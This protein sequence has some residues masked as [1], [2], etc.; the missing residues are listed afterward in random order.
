MTTAI[1]CLE[2]HAAALFVHDVEGRLVCT[3]DIGRPAAPRFYLGRSR[4]GAIWR[5]RHDV[6]ATLVAALE[7]L[8][9]DEPMVDDLRTPPRHTN[10]YTKLLAPVAKV[11][12]GPAM[13]F[14]APPPPPANT[15]A[16]DTSNA[17]LLRGTFDDWLADVPHR[18]PFFVAL[19]SDEPAAVCASARITPAACEAGVETRLAFR[20]RGLAGAA[21]QAW[22]RAVTQTGAAA[23]YSTSWDNTASQRV[24]AKLEL[25]TY[26]CDFHVT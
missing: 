20:G 22:A 26:G 9:R 24:A 10:D 25:V 15:L 4:E 5:F 17:D 14:T 21:V 11:W 13:R 6:P 7:A 16:I 1:E 8:C 12:S 3:N 2:L 19:A 23:L 18:Q